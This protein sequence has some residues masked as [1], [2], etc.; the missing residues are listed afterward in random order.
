MRVMDFCRS[1]PPGVHFVHRID[2]GDP[3]PVPLRGGRFR[4]NQLLSRTRS[5]TDAIARS[6]RSIFLLR[7]VNLFAGSCAE[8]VMDP[9]R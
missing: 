4:R 8:G 6:S 7:A 1:I 3:V 5:A 2:A 9:V